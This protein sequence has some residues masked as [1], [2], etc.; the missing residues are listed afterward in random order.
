MTYYLIIP[1]IKKTA[2]L[3][4]V[5]CILTKVNEMRSYSDKV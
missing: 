1:E 5:S 2:C 4:K 3:V